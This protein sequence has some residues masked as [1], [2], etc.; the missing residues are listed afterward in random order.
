MLSSDVLLHEHCPELFPLTSEVL[1]TSVLLASRPALRSKFEDLL[2]GSDANAALAR[3]V[4][5]AKV[6]Q[7]RDEK[8]ADRAIEL[9]EECLKR[10]DELHLDSLLRTPPFD[11]TFISRFAQVLPISFHGLSKDGNPV[12]I[13]KYG[14]ADTAALDEMW[15]QGEELSVDGCNA[16]TLCFI[17]SVPE[18]VTRVLMNEESIRQGRTVDRIHAIIDVNNVSMAH[19]NGCLRPFVQQYATNSRQV[20]PEIISRVFITRSPWI[21]SN[22][23]WPVVQWFFNRLTV[24]KVQLLDVDNTVT[25]LPKYI[26]VE[27]LPPFLGGTCTCLSCTSGVMDGGAMADWERKERLPWCC[28][29]IDKKGALPDSSDVPKTEGLCRDVEENTVPP[30]GSSV[31]EMEIMCKDVEGTEVEIVAPAAGNVTEMEHVRKDAGGQAV[32]TASRNVPKLPHVSRDADGGGSKKE[33]TSSF[34]SCKSLRD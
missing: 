13:I 27:T 30:P 16:F 20:Y 11:Y 5:V 1:K 9:F 14:D 31:P 2:I 19:F 26:D 4:W 22:V 18:Y 33:R 8:A 12:A 3:W 15:A 29:A 28:S 6:E 17:R 25:V 10:R 21:V 32:P 24:A 34:E 7:N 23:A